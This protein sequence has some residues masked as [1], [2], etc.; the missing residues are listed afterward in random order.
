[1][2]FNP[3]QHFRRDSKVVFAGLAILCMVTFV[4]S[5]GMGRGDMLDQMTN[6]ATR[7]GRNA[8]A[9]S[10]YGKKY[11]ARQLYLTQVG[12]QLASDYMSYA[13]SVA[14][15]GMAQRAMAG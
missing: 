8:W 11:D 12:R 5:S 4:R 13:T 2:A 7:G 3:S 6:W 10:L 14:Q 15:Q 1:M 9:A